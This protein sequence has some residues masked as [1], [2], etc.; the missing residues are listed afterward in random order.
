MVPTSGNTIFIHM[1]GGYSKLVED[2][3]QKELSSVFGQQD[4]QEF[5]VNNSK[6]KYHGWCQSGTCLAL[7]SLDDIS[8]IR[9]ES[10]QLPN[11]LASV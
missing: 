3:T 4:L 5:E 1:E 11:I 2:P 7:W 9:R 8:H 10:N 6:Q